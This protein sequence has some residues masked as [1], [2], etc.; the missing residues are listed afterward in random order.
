MQGTGRK[1]HFPLIRR[2]R[3]LQRMEDSEPHSSPE[4]STPDVVR[5][6]AGDT[7]LA[8]LNHPAISERQTTA[9]DDLNLKSEPTRHVDYLSHSWKEEDIWSS[10]RHI[11]AKRK[12]Y[13]N[14][15]RL[16]NASWRTWTKFKYQLKTVS[17]ET[18]NW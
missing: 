17:P 10:W 1:H 3:L 2:W 18:L 14:W 5:Q 11:V 6:S 8:K 9:G 16:E 13:S 4:P 15:S 12:V 7:S